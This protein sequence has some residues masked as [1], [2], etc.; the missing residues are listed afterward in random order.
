MT[1]AKPKKS[2]Y[3]R[4]NEDT[5]DTLKIM[6]TKEKKTQEDFAGELIEEGI[7]K[8]KQKENK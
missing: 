5:K 4:I 8:R 7:E 6:A 1:D 3:A 2:L